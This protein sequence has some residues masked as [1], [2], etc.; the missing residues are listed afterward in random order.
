M[1]LEPGRTCEHSVT[2]AEYGRFMTELLAG[3]FPWA[4]LRQAQKLLRLGDKYGWTSVDQ[5]CRRAL[6]FD[7]INVA[8][9]E[10]I[11]KLGLE[12]GA[13]PATPR[14]SQTVIQMPLRFE[15]PTS[16]FNHHTE[17]ERGGEDRD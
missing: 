14:S 10:R 6:A 12:R 7:L 15:R 8:R 17:Q 5:A 9:V 1:G 3:P 4:K 13:L 11:I 2:P 16:H